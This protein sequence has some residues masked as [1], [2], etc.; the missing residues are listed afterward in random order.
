MNDFVFYL[1]L[2]IVPTIVVLSSIERHKEKKRAALELAKYEQ[3][4]IDRQEWMMRS[5]A[6]TCC[7]CG[8]IAPPILGTGNRYRCGECGNQFAGAAHRM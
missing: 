6:L 7:R 5:L 1:L 4:Q 8:K 2:F 3:N